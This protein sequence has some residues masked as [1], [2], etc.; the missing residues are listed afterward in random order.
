M[1]GI[2]QLLLLLL[3][4]RRGFEVA[5]GQQGGAASRNTPLEGG[6]KG[7]SRRLHTK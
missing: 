6:G 2:E 7:G 3:G 5:V 4:G 1:K